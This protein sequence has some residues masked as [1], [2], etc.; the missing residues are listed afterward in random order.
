MTNTDN[1]ILAS[2]LTDNERIELH[3]EAIHN[4]HTRAFLG[5]VVTAYPVGAQVWMRD[6]Y[7]TATVLGPV[8][9]LEWCILTTDADGSESTY[10][11]TADDLRPA[12][13]PV[14]FRW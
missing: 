7:N 5:P 2:D 14:A 4:V 3:L 9:D 6:H 12:A 1:I 8:G 11:Y 10:E 13:A